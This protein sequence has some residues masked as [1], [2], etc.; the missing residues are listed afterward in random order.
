[1]ISGVHPYIYVHI[2]FCL[3]H[4]KCDIPHINHEFGVLA[5]DEELIQLYVL[6]MLM[7]LLI[8]TLEVR[9]D[10]CFVDVDGIVDHHCL[11]FL[12]MMCS[13]QFPKI[14]IKESCYESLSLKRY[15]LE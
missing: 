14:T 9:G 8:I 7:K 5:L 3:L 15:Y 1:M 10:C 2:L 6:L 13:S 11:N 12:F 4:G